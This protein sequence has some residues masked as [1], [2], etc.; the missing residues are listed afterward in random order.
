M[1][2]ASSVTKEVAL[3][4]GQE[5]L[6]KLILPLYF[7][8]DPITKEEVAIAQ[9]SWDQILNDQSQE[10][11]KRSSEDPTFGQENP[12][13]TTFFFT[14][15]Y[16]RLFDVHP[17]ARYMFKAG[18][19]SQG[20]FLIQLMT[21]ALTLVLEEEK[22]NRV[23][24]N[25]AVKHNERGVKAIEYGI[26]GEVMFWTLRVVL[27]PEHLS[28]QTYFIRTKIFSRML[29]VM[30]PS[31]LA[32][33]LKSGTE[34]QQGVRLMHEHTSLKRKVEDEAEKAR[35]MHSSESE[36]PPLSLT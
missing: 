18:L 35:S 26:V 8:E 33:E 21:L 24:L 9:S 36:T 29:K 7:N 6:V 11:K 2:G 30:V 1:G 4:H 22:F 20:K 28:E 16:A 3:S 31:A 32:H 10:F 17:A 12:S 27:G 34:S 15:F 14:T 25:L 19:K 5:Q 13:C 23:L